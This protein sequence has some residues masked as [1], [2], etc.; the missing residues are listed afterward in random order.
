[1]RIIKPRLKMSSRERARHLA[2]RNSGIDGKHRIVF[3]IERR[4]RQGKSLGM[5]YVIVRT[6]DMQDTASER[7]RRLLTGDSGARLIY[8]TDE[9]IQPD[10]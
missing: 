4:N 3:E 2:E 9:T 1:M 6:M 10:A 8:S 5:E 7:E